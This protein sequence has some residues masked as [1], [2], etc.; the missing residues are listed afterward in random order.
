[1]VFQ[2]H[3]AA[4]LKLYQNQRMI[5]H[6]IWPNSAVLLSQNW[7][8]GHDRIWNENK[9]ALKKE[10]ANEWAKRDKGIMTK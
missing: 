4:N 2:L 8:S 10:E 5:A 9:W 6:P 3:C 1:M 7:A